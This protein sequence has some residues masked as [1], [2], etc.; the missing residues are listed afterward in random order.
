V[1]VVRELLNHGAKVDTTDAYFSTLFSADVSMA[2]RGRDELIR[3]LALCL[4]QQAYHV[5]F[6][7]IYSE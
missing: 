6:K 7:K 2:V 3:E 1:E 5:R 4:H